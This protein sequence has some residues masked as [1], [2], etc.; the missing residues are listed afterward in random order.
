MLSVCMELCPECYGAVQVKI[1]RAKAHLELNPF[2]YVKDNIKLFI[3]ILSL[4][5]DYG[6]SSS[7]IR[8]G[9]NLVM[10]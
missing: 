10:I 5:E 6:E 7:F 8:C 3:E 2:I 4:K 1:R 9:G